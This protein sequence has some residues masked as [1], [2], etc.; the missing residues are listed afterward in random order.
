LKLTALL[1]LL[2]TIAFGQSP[3]KIRTYYI[4]ADE[5]HWDYAPGIW[6]FHCHIDDHMDAGMVTLYKVEP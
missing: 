4:A 5:V 6:M 2:S 3:G 1:V